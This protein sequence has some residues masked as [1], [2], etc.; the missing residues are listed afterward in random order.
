MRFVFMLAPSGTDSKAR[1]L[2]TMPLRL[3]IL[4]SVTHTVKGA[5]FASMTPL[6]E[7]FVW[8]SKTANTGNS[9]D[10]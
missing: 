8:P 4:D 3:S 7:P 2:I 9:A 1:S 5:S 10:T 6:Y